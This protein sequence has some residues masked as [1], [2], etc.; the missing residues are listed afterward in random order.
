M[1]G[2]SGRF[3]KKQ[4]AMTLD[5]SFE[6][7]SGITVV[8]G[9]SGAGKT[10]FLNM[11]SGVGAPD[12]GVLYLGE[13]VLF[14]SDKGIDV[15]PRSRRIG[16]VFQQPYLF[17]HMTV[18]SNISFSNA[19]VLKETWMKDLLLETGVDLLL[20]AYPGNLSGGEKQRVN[21]LR[22]LASQPEAL[23][24]DEP[25]SSLDAKTRKIC[26]D[27]L[28]DPR[29]GIPSVLVTHDRE[30]AS[31]MGTDRFFMEFGT[32]RNAPEKIGVFP[33]RYQGDA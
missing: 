3:V 8:T 32:L 19:D 2:L 22:T 7:R 14:D 9:H 4:G 13:K 31:R 27:I 11:L 28:L 10:T 16:H 26:Q 15:P 1:N 12:E 18:A 21:L 20:S 24:L 29:R 23:L 33:T 5:L 30:E 25:F 17:P 6:F